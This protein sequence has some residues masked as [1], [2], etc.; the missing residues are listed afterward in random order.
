MLDA[1]PGLVHAWHDDEDWEAETAQPLH[2][3]CSAGSVET[4][5]LL[6][7]RGADISANRDGYSYCRSP[8]SLACGSG[9]PALVSLLLAR[10]AD[11]TA[12]EASEAFSECW[13]NTPLLVA[14]CSA[15]GARFDRLGVIRLLLEDGRVPVD[16]R[17]GWGCTALLHACSRGDMDMVRLLVWEGHADHTIADDEGK[18]P[19]D[20]AKDPA[21]IALLKVR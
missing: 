21:L 8:L 20:V 13:W 16:A 4:A 5:A 9:R 2:C 1:Q 17:D 7:D 6:L 14:C 15:R 3:A 18:R 12:E 19:V 11:P 10:G